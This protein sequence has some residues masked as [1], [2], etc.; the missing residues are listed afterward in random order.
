[1]NEL[2]RFE[3]VKYWLLSNRKPIGLIM[4]SLSG[5]FRLSLTFQGHTDVADTLK[6]IADLLLVGAAATAAS[7]ATQNDEHFAEKKQ[8]LVRARS[9]KYPVY[10][11]R[12]TDKRNTEQLK[13]ALAD[14]ELRDG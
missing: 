5:V 3:S 2:S 6:G 11:R 7:G 8:A 4:L 14:S 10:T 13:D 12:R 9:G 1:M